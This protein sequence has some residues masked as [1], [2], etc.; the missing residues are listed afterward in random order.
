ME[1]LDDTNLITFVGKVNMDRNSPDFYIENTEQSIIDT[2]WMIEKSNFLHTKPIIT[3]RFIPTCSDTLMKELSNII[4]EYN[5]PMQSHLSENENE[6]LWVKKLCPWSKFYGDV[7]DSYSMM[8]NKTIMAHC[9]FS[10]DD[11]IDLMKKTNTF[12][13]HCPSSNASLSSGIA[14]IKKYLSKNLNVGFG[15]DVAGGYSLS[16]F[17]E[18]VIAI[19]MSKMYQK[20]IDKNQNPLTINEVFYM[21]TLGGGEFFG[22]VGSFEKGYEFDA[23]VLDDNEIQTSREF[24]IAQR[25][26]RIIYLWQKVK[27]ESKIVKGKKIF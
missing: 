19:L 17:N 16:I 13:A 20:Y 9:V 22:N 5:L 24:N 6:I 8:N 11:E 4:K 21:A 1:M 15:S 25:F 27:L 3:P 26:E 12:V 14:P 7:Y 18:M 23:I 10:S 2:R